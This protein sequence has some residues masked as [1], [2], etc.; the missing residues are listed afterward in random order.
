MSGGSILTA[1]IVGFLLIVLVFVVV[2]TRR[3]RGRRRS[4]QHWNPSD[5]EIEGDGPPLGSR[6]RR[7]DGNGGEAGESG[8]GGGDGGD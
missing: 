5:R 7:H 1:S 4:D 2:S 3:K 6:R 8:D